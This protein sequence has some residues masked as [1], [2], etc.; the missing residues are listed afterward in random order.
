M[1]LINNKNIN[2]LGFSHIELMLGIIVLVIIGS[3][4][5]LVVKSNPVHAGSWT[6]LS[7]EDVNSKPDTISGISGQACKVLVGSNY[8]VQIELSD[9][10]STFINIHYFV[11]HP[12]NNN[13]SAYDTVSNENSQVSSTSHTA[14]HDLTVSE[15]DFFGVNLTDNSRIRQY[16]YFFN[17][18][19]AGP[20]T[21]T[22]PSSGYINPSKLTDCPGSSPVVRPTPPPAPP[23]TTPLVDVS[24]SPSTFSNTSFSDTSYSQTSSS[25]S[26]T[27]GSSTVGSLTTGSSTSANSTANS[28]SQH[29]IVK[30][31]SLSTVIK[32][33]QQPKVGLLQNIITIFKKLI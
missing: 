14:D 13:D 5:A 26:S 10:S 27:A 20:V 18:A 2:N 1:K 6:A 11:Y 19:Q 16:L 7:T 12:T 15:D 28:S 24:T 4:G 22:S 32:A 30:K 33:K 17:S 25:D 21:T 9:N 31:H 29:P 8:T 23:P 3:I